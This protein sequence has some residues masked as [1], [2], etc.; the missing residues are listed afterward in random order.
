M[1]TAKGEGIWLGQAGLRRCPWVSY[2]E[3][4]GMGAEIGVQASSLMDSFRA[5]ADGGTALIL[6]QPQLLKHK[7]GFQVQF[8]TLPKAWKVYVWKKESSGTPET[9]L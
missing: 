1:Q 5:W 8:S 9:P 7:G 2:Q 6:S 4:V 3:A